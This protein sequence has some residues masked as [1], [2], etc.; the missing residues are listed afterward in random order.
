MDSGVQ[1]VHENKFQKIF[2][3]IA[4]KRKPFSKLSTDPTENIF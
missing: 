2:F 3:S 4:K 1:K